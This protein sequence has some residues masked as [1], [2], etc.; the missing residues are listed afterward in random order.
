MWRHARVYLR[1]ATDDDW[2]V[3]LGTNAPSEWFGLVAESYMILGIG[4]AFVGSD[5]RWWATFR[6]VPGVRHTLTAHKA[7]RLTLDI[8]RDLGIKLYAIADEEVGGSEVWLSRLGFKK[9]DEHF[10]ERAVWEWT[11]YQ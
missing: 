4:G 11:P 9:T 3:V 1:R 2:R 6:R 8:A 5:G 10:K 7:A